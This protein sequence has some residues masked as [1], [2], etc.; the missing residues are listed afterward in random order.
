MLHG[1]CNAVKIAGARSLYC[2][3]LP[4]RSPICTMRCGT[5]DVTLL[6]E[7]LATTI[8]RARTE[9][10]LRVVA[11]RQGGKLET[12]SRGKLPLETTSFVGRGRELSR[13]EVLLGRTRLLTLVGVGDSG[14]HRLR[15][16]RVRRCPHPPVAD[17]RNDAAGTDPVGR[18]VR[19]GWFRTPGR[20]A[21]RSGASPPVGR[22]GGRAAPD[23]RRDYRVH[24]AGR[25]SAP[26]GAGLAGARRGGGRDG[27]GRR[28][29]DDGRR[30]RGPCPRG[31]GDRAGPSS[32]QPSQRP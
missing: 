18:D 13:V 11:G 32:R 17:E 5:C 28:P 2:A 7:G 19:T 24:R 15:R 8:S 4:Q 9:N 10:S 20:G 29:G 12:T 6:L 3:A 22:R 27:L 25:F 23:L 14:I 30:G 1:Y 21:R 16:G 26:P 31:A